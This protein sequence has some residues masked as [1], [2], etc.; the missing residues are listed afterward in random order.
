M[1]NILSAG[2]GGNHVNSCRAMSLIEILIAAAICGILGALLFSSMGKVSEK[3]KRTQ[4][5]SNLRQIHTALL[6]FSADNRMELPLYKKAGPSYAEELY[7]QRKV[8]PYLRSEDSTPWYKGVE[9]TFRCPS[10]EKPYSG[11][12]SYGMNMA[13]QGMTFPQLQRSVILLADEADYLIYPSEN[14]YQTTGFKRRHKEGDHVLF[15]DGHSEFFDNV[16]TPS[17]SPQLWSPL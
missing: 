9:K 16:P 13:L 4:C 6:S 14:L 11:V 17:Q 3:G 8:A 12:L 7:W 10:D 1:R 2:K 15:T 5:L